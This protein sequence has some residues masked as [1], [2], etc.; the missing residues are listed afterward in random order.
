MEFQV[1]RARDYYDAS[2]PLDSLLEPAGRGVFRVLSQTYRGLL[3]A[4]EKRDYDVFSERVK[5]SRW[6][7]MR[8]MAQALP[9]RWGWA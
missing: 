4:I 1:K 6:R 2:E 9:A 8:L 5:L 3:D 7:K